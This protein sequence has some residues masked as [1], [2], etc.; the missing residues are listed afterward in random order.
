MTDV[1]N[2]YNNLIQMYGRPD[3]CVKCGKCEQRCPQHLKIRDFL[4]DVKA[5]LEG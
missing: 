2:Y 4:A 3:D 1:Y 5:T